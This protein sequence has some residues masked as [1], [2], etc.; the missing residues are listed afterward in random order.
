MKKTFFAILLSVSLPLSVAYAAPDGG[1]QLG[2]GIVNERVE[3]LAQELNLTDEQKAQVKT[4][5]REAHVRHKAIFDETRIRLESVLNE[6]QKAKLSE[7][8]KNHPP[9]G[10]GVQGPQE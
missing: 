3:H 2:K 8:M 5:I 7:M 6:E 10:P 4:I 9:H 1:P